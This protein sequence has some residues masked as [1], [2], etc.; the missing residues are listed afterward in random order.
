M[1]VAVV[2]DHAGDRAWLTEELKALLQRRRLEGTVTAFDRGGA[3]LEAARRERFTLAFLDIYM[4][5]MD[6]VET[7]RALR[8][9]DPDCLLVFS[10]SSA[11]HALEGYRVQA[12]QYLV[13]PYHTAELER[14]FVQLDRLLP[15][16]ER[17][18]EL[19]AERRTVRVR[20]RD[21]LW[22][23]HFQHQVRLHIPK[24]ETLSTRL[25][26][27]AFTKLLAGDSRFFVCGRG[28]LVNLDHA[29]D[30]DGRDFRLTDG[31]RLPVSRDLAS[32]ARSAF[33]DH[34]FHSGGGTNL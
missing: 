2:D 12:V 21:I 14:L 19:R 15:A 31:T 16:P 13:K 9:F 28:L 23:E 3:F 11:D 8:A 6:G 33:G 34:L 20:L 32:A 22:A 18:V 4:E 7:A 29:A 10:T 26:F 27:G 30:F 17:Y 25:T 24:G 5:P 1:R